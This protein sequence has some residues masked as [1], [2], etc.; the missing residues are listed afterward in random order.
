[1][2]DL[3]KLVGAIVQLVWAVVLALIVAVLKVVR[4]GWFAIAAVASI[5]GRVVSGKRQH[6]APAFRAGM[7]G[8][9]DKSGRLPP[10]PSLAEYHAAGVNPDLCSMCQKQMPERQRE[11]RYLAIDGRPAII[12]PRC[13]GKNVTNA[14]PAEEAAF[15]SRI[16]TRVWNTPRL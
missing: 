4:L 15:M 10:A 5:P 1:M 13:W 11:W 2:K 9:K 6:S 8:T 12:C 7:A 16:S 14:T 3:F